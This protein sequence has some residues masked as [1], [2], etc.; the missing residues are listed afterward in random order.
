MQPPLTWYEPELWLAV[1]TAAA[2]C[3]SRS[4]RASVCSPHHPG[5]EPELW[6]DVCIKTP[7]TS[8]YNPTL[9]PLVPNILKLRQS[10]V[11]KMTSPTHRAI[12]PKIEC[13]Q[14]YASQGGLIARL[15]E[16]TYAIG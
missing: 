10:Q 2:S 5:Y 15:T 13:Y 1:F 14:C 7:R 4:T 6:L 8:V 12:N 3:S 16:D 11:L 9:N